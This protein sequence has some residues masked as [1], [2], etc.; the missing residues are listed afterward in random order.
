MSNLHIIDLFKL[1]L[2]EHKAAGGFLSKRGAPGLLGLTLTRMNLRYMV[3]VI[4]LY[5]L[6]HTCK[7]DIALRFY[8]FFMY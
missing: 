3:N 4:F 6:K 5:R 1:A 8:M 2:E 7:N